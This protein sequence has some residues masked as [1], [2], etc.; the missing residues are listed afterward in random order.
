MGELG[1]VRAADLRTVSRRGRRINPRVWERMSWVKAFG[2]GSGGRGWGATTLSGS[3]RPD[4][5]SRSSEVKI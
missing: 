3:Y 1:A 2:F 5:R 4:R